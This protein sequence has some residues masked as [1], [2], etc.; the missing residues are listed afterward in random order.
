M[1]M[2][3]LSIIL[4]HIPSDKLYLLDLIQPDDIIKKMLLDQ[5]DK[6]IIKQTQLIEQKEK[7]IENIILDS[8]KVNERVIKEYQDYLQ[9]LQK[10]K[11]DTEAR[12][13][14]DFI[15]QLKEIQQ[16]TKEQLKELR[17]K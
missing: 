17:L 5:Y 3:T 16:K 2:I 13:C 12:K 4:S 15:I 8:I 7:Y 10:Q 1:L 14:S 9:L 6:Q 11:K